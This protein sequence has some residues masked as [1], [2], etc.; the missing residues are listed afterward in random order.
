M[1]TYKHSCIP[2]LLLAVLAAGLTAYAGQGTPAPAPAPLI[3]PAGFKVEVFAENV[4][5][6][7]SMALGSQGT[8]FVGT[9]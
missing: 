8:V 2:A 6:A 9:Q 7:R 5:N 4:A 3:V 1:T